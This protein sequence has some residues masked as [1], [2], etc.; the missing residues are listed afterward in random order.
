V[1]LSP[2]PFR[3]L[4]SSLFA[5]IALILLAGLFSILGASLWLQSGERATVVSQ[6][7][8][9]HFVDRIAEAVRLLEAEG[10]AH[11]D[12]AL[13]ALQT[14]DLRLMLVTPEQIFPATPRGQMPAMLNSRLGSEREV[15]AQG[16]H[17]GM[18][19]RGNL[20][21][22]FDVR[23]RDGQWIRISEAN[24]LAAPAIPNALIAQLLITLIVVTAVVMLAVRQV[25]KPLQ[26]LA[27][28]ADELGKDLDAAPLAEEGPSESRRAAQAFNRMQGRIKH[29]VEERAR[30]LAAVSHDLRT[31]LTRLRLRTELVDDEKLR[32][33]MAGDLASMATMIDGTLDYLRG[34]QDSEPT[35]RID[36]NALLQS[37]AEDASLL[38]NAISVE[39][40]AQ[41]PYSGRLSAMRRALQNMIDNAIKYGH[42]AHIRVEDDSDR[43]RIVVEDEGPGIPLAEIAR[44]S[45]PYYRL[46]A[47]RSR[48]TGG[49][50]LGLSIVKDIAVMHGGELLLA[51][52]SEGGL[53]ATLVLP[54]KTS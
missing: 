21:R 8:G 50:G 10:P 25:T 31:P 53:S 9:L 7:R 3:A 46:D 5:Y 6:A 48:D 26:R 14:G 37:L 51:N 49:I 41:M 2:H 11:R 42:R 19:Q 20:Q 18:Q 24:E 36:I 4:R 35:R 29:L 43:L 33:Q 12:A 52:R 13:A 40:L 17:G 15:R 38:G 44:V 47:S 16:G 22:S 34:F 1:R 32:D 54:R 39:G 45:E 28:A 30:A 27:L 23:L